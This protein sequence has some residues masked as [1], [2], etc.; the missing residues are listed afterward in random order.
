MIHVLCTHKLQAKFK[1]SEIWILILICMYMRAANVPTAPSLI[2]FNICV[3]L[4]GNDRVTV[5]CFD[6]TQKS[7][8]LCL[9]SAVARIRAYI[10]DG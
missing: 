7:H 6:S 4:N 3:H 8:K 5:D 1:T 9:N 10:F 2:D